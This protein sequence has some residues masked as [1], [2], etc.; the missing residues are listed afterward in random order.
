MRSPSI[1]AFSESAVAAEPRDSALTSLTFGSTGER[2]HACE[3]DGCDKAFSD[4]SSLARHRRVRC[5]QRS[6][7]FKLGADLAIASQIHTGKRPYKCPDH[8]CGKTYAFRCTV[9][10]CSS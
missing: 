10:L 1:P 3:Y 5:H 9:C 2:P 6:T 7:G 4:S 8:S